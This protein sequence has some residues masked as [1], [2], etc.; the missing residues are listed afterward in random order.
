MKNIKLKFYFQFSPRKIAFID[1]MLFK[2]ENN[3]LQTTLYGKPTDKQEF[4]EAK[5]EHPRF[6]KNSILYV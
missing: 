2:D 4:L 6:L 5:S 3:N 1:A